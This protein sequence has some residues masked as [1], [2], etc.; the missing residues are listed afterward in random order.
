MARGRS[1]TSKRRFCKSILHCGRPLQSTSQLTVRKWWRPSVFSLCSQLYIIPVLFHGGRCRL[2]ADGTMQTS[3]PQ[4]VVPMHP[5]VPN[6]L[7]SSIVPRRFRTSRS[8]RHK[9]KLRR[10]CRAAEQD[11]L[12]LHSWN[13][14]AG[15]TAPRRAR[16]VPRR[17]LGATLGAKRL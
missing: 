1:G 13:A 7:P 10:N 9:T 3:F 17:A 12:R 8:N 6:E 5:L 4:D 15:Q 14:S 16:N 11:M 2:V